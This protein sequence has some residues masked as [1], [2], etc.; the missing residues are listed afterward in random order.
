MPEAVCPAPFDSDQNDNSISGEK[1]L[2]VHYERLL[3]LIIETIKEQQ[4]E[5]ENY[6]KILVNHGH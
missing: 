5:I 3:P 2:T 4:L 6:E 1:Y